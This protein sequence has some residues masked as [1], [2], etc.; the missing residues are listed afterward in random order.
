MSALSS[1]IIMMPNQND[2]IVSP[3]TEPICR[4]MSQPFPR[5]FAI[6]T[7]SGTASPAPMSSDSKVSCTVGQTCEAISAATGRFV[8]I[9]TPRSPVRTPPIHE[10][11]WETID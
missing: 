5:S 2:G 11:Y 8:Q 7:P 4:A 1:R 3:A 9:E 10:K 6:S